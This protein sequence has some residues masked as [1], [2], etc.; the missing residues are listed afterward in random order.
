[1]LVLLYNMAKQI[2]TTPNWPCPIKVARF[3]LDVL[4]QR[5]CRDLIAAVIVVLAQY[6]WTW[7]HQPCEKYLKSVGGLQITAH[8]IRYSFHSDA[9]S[10]FTAGFWTLPMAFR[11]RALT[12]LNRRGIL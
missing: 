3:H 10:C 1:M 6:L 7:K 11:G 5:L 8:N 4:K 9:N 2:A 12:T